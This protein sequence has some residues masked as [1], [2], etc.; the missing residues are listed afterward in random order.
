[1]LLESNYLMLYEGDLCL[2]LACILLT[3]IEVTLRS[4]L[5]TIFLA[6]RS[7]H[8]QIIMGFTKPM[9]AEESNHCF[10]IRMMR[11]EHYLMPC[12][13]CKR[14]TWFNGRWRS[15][16]KQTLPRPWSHATHMCWLLG[17]WQSTLSSILRSYLFKVYPSW[18]LK[19]HNQ[20][21][22]THSRK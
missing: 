19:E 6:F 3:S 4:C 5:S 12:N 11:A 16:L 1:M 21:A 2:L 20:T 22:V 17:D 10:C 13:D 8:S 14:S 15:V 9:V 18:L 7:N